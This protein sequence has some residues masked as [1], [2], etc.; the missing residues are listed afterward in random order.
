MQRTDLPSHQLFSE[1]AKRLLSQRFGKNVCNLLGGVDRVEKDRS[2]LHKASKVMVLDCNV[3]SSWGELGAV[4][5]FN[6]TLIVFPNFD[7]E[8][9]GGC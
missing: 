8:G 7:V 5:N 3:L 1:V 6:A 9:R 4:G 2:I